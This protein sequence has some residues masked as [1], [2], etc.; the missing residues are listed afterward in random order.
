MMPKERQ[1]VGSSVTGE[2][3]LTAQEEEETTGQPMVE[4]EEEEEK[5]EGIEKG[6]EVEEDHEDEDKRVQEA[7][8]LFNVPMEE[9]SDD[10]NKDD[11][12]SSDSD[13]GSDF[14]DDDL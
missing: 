2:T 9:R 14:S 12:D 6:G 13:Y 8:R 10:G 1:E 4:E 5:V 3:N 7:L 11:S